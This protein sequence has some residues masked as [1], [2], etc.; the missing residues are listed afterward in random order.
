MIRICGRLISEDASTWLFA[1]A[2]VLELGA[3]LAEPGPVNKGRYGMVALAIR[4]RAARGVS[5]SPRRASAKVLQLIRE[6][7][8]QSAIAG[9]CWDKAEAKLEELIRTLGVGKIV[10]V[11]EGVFAKV[12]DLFAEANSVIVP[13][14]MR[15]HKL[16]ICDA[17]GK[18]IRLRDR[19]RQNRS[20]KAAGKRNKRG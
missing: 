7:R 8:Q 12:V 20:Q 14:A 11:D 4:K 9:K 6:H 19:P 3:G 16:V 1:P 13:K 10:G 17:G 18:E 15:R 2:A 5:R